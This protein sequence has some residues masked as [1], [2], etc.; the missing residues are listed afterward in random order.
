[1]AFVGPVCARTAEWGPSTWLG[2][3]R[4]EAFGFGVG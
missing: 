1:M 4:L 3:G 2:V